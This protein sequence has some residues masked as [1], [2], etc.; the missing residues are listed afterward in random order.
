[1]TFRI[2][3]PSK[4]A[5]SIANQNKMSLIKKYIKLDVLILDIKKDKLDAIVAFRRTFQTG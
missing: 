1:M 3:W 4:F 5:P 2:F